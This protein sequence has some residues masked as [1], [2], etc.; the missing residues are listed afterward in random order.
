MDVLEVLE[1]LVNGGKVEMECFHGEEVERT[2]KVRTDGELFGFG[3]GC[4]LRVQEVGLHIDLSQERVLLEVTDE[5][6]VDGEGLLSHD[7]NVL[8][9]WLAEFQED[10]EEVI[11]E[12]RGRTSSLQLY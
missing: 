10:V 11:D 12:A 7:S 3:E 6:I 4:E 5:S 1:V 8:D 9:E 2:H